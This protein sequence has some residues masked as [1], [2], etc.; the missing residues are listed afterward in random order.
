MA[1][2]ILKTRFISTPILRYF[3]PTRKIRIE[4]NI[5]AFAILGILS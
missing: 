2:R 1:F 5:S 4:T 3:D